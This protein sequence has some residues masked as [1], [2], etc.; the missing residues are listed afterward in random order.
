MASLVADLGKDDFKNLKYLFLNANKIT[1]AGAAKLLTA[2]NAGG[3]PKLRNNGALF[4][5]SI[6]N[7]VSD[8]AVAAVHAALAKRSVDARR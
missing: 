4:M 5:F 8:S 1:D 6:G 2:I 3:L 7:S